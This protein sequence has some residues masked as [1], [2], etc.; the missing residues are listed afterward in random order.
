MGIWPTE[1]DVT[2]PIIPASWK[3]QSVVPGV[4]WPGFPAPEPAAALGLLLQ[5]ESSQWLPA[6]QIREHQFRQIEALLHHAYESTPYHRERWQGSYDPAL[7]ITP[8][9]LAVLP[10]LARRELQAR[11]ESMKS[12]RVPAAHGGIGESRSSGSTGTPV[13]VLKTQLC[14]LIWNT[15]TLRDHVWHR[16]HLGGK[17]AAIRH[18]MTEGESG[19][20]GSATDG[21]IATGHLFTSDVRTDVETHLRWLEE[22]QPDYLITYPSI[23]RELAKSSIERG[24]RLTKLREARTF[25]EALAPELRELCLQAW[26]VPVTDIY[27]AD[28]VGYIALQCP[29]HEHYHVQSESVFVEILDHDGRNCVPGEVGRIV[30]T[31][32][33]NFAMPLIRYELGDYAEVGEPCSCGRGLPVLKRIMGRVRN[34]LVTATGERYW[35]TFGVRTLAEIAPITQAQFAQKEYTLIEARLVTAAPLT[36]DQEEKLRQ[37][38]L[39]RL[40]EGFRLNIA[41]SK[42]IPRSKSGKFED[43]VCEVQAR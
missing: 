33:H 16:R 1:T 37:T 8:E 25:G 34:M 15:L 21:L 14:K 2:E 10:I 30:V 23:L 39:S 11:F 4:V 42:E 28:E 17:L 38:V 13:R 35:P 31:S 19:N 40:P 7:P 20:W 24:V 29:E 41:Y 43:F 36:R 6:E 5:L 22:R 26:S 9:R 18:G 12:A 32:L 27:S 3:I